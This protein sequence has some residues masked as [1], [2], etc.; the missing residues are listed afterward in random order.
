MKSSLKFL[1]LNIGMSSSLAGLSAIVDFE[2]IDVVFL[3]EICLTSDQIEQFLRGYR[4]V[5]NIDQENINRP[6]IALAW[7][8][9]I[10][11]ENVSNLAPCRLHSA[12]IGS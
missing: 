1:T 12:T 9:E 4:A 8:Q 6:G 7:R 10:P 3:Q 11:V 2:D 5:S